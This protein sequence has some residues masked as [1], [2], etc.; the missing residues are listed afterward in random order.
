MATYTYA[1]GSSVSFNATADTLNFTSGD[2]ASITF[3]QVGSDLR[4]GT[5][6]QLMTLRGT[7]YANMLKTLQHC[8]PVKS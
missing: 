2:A 8:C 4:V 1:A 7:N 5:G 3:T 6:S